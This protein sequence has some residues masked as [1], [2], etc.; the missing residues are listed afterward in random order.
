MQEAFFVRSA[1]PGA[2]LRFLERLARRGEM[3]PPEVLI[4]D[5]LGEGQWRALPVGGLAGVAARLALAFPPDVLHL[6]ETPDGWAWTRY[7]SDG[8]SEVGTLPRKRLLEQRA[9]V[10]RWAQQQGLPLTRLT[11][12]PHTLDYET[13]AQ[14]DQRSLLLEDTPRLYRFSLG[15]VQL[16]Q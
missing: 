1:S 5:A 6:Q 4:S 3:L 7:T 12:P 2:V 13:V 9:P 8:P 14:L 15:A 16:P 11:R 10:V